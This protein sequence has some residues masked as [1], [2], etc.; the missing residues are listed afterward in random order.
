MSRIVK[1]KP[2]SGFGDSE[3][4]HRSRDSRSRNPRIRP[5]R[6]V[7]LTMWNSLSAKVGNNFAGKQRSLGRYSLL[8][9]SVH[10]V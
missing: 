6:S 10:G 9:D 4:T 5:W 2:M 7:T 3:V 8:A 1:V